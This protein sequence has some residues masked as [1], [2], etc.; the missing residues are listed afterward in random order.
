VQTVIEEGGEL[1]SDGETEWVTAPAVLIGEGGGFLEVLKCEGAVVLGW[2]EE[3]GCVFS[4]WWSDCASA[5]WT[6][7]ERVCRLD[8]GWSQ[9]IRSPAVDT[10][11]L[12]VFGCTRRREAGWSVDLRGG[13]ESDWGFVVEE[14]VKVIVAGA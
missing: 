9:G 14:D 12:W 7:F 10:F 8:R 2:N 1:D 13:F 11:A 6:S 5:N 4:R 3:V